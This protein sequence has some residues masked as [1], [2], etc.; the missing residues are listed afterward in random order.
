MVPVVSATFQSCTSHFLGPGAQVHNLIETV[1]KIFVGPHACFAAV[2][3]MGM[4]CVTLA[5]SVGGMP[6]LK[7]DSQGRGLCPSGKPS[8]RAHPSDGCP[9]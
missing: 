9:D 1:L 2:S 7:S 3:L 6:M 5:P 8:A 4:Y